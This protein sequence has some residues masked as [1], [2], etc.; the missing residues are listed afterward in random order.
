MDKDTLDRLRAGESGA[1]RDLLA[2]YR[3]KVVS[4]CFRF[5]RNREDAEE[6]A[7]DVFMEVHRSLSSF[8]EEAE[9]STWI[10]R[11]AVTKS[12][13]LL[14]R[15]KRKKRFDALLGVRTAA[16]EMESLPAAEEAGP[17]QALEARERSRILQDSI[18]GLVENQRIAITLSR[19]EGLDARKIAEVLG[20]TAPAVDALLHRAKENL[21]K[22]LSRYYA[23]TAPKEP[24]DG[25]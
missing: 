22:K 14:R 13:D 2:A 6:A 4:T 11:I 8:R 12:L 25:P 23:R 9:L 16:V 24:N 3:D 19:I 5:L 21:K 20:T 18:D 7:L 1:F 10:F 15:K 17:E